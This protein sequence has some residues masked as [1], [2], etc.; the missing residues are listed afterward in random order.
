MSR[1][2]EYRERYG[3]TQDEAVAAIQRHAL[4]RG[5]KVTPGLDQCA[6]SRHENGHKRP[7]PY[8]QTLYCEVYGA[9]PAELGFRLALPA[10]SVHH[11]DVD[12][13]EFLAGAAGFVATAALPDVP[14][15]P[16]RRLGDSDVAHL[17]QSV[18]NL[19][20]LSEQHGEDA[21]Y[22]LTTRLYFRL[23]GLTER[24]S[25]DP[26]T[27]RTLRELAGELARRIGSINS[28]VGRYEDARHWQLEAMH[29]ARL[30]DAEWITVGAMASMAR[31]ASEQRRPREAID[32]ATTAQRTAGPAATPRLRSMLLVR[33]AL[34][35]AGARDA[36]SARATLRHAGGLADQ[37][38][39]DHDP[40]WMDYY[41]PADFACFEHRVAL[42]LGD[43]AAAEGGARTALA[44]SDPVAYPRDHA[45]D[46]VNL[47]AVLAH[48]RKIDESTAVG[49]QA[50]TAAAN[51][52]SGRVKRELRGVARRLT[53]Y[54]DEPAVG[55]FLMLV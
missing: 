15:V 4:A 19:Y 5:D 41:G 17:R 26:A 55:E 33:E 18:R 37:P 43:D 21:A 16:T 39:H 34:G 30:A 29:W 1:L 45:I 6:L 28:H 42:M 46:L 54:R 50:A 20:G 53:P 31:Q 44:M 23:R 35:H 7:G 22:G 47:A 51:L 36:K 14:S 10:E 11:E 49:S 24:T 13:R 32:L 9:T 8:Y 12:R 3:L 27:G 52:D 40:R 25:Y 2:K 48:R 38:R